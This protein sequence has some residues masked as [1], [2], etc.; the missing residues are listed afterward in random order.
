MASNYDIR[1]VCLLQGSS[2]AMSIFLNNK[3]YEPFWYKI[4]R[5]V[6][7]EINTVVKVVDKSQ[8]YEFEEHVPLPTMS[9]A[10]RLLRYGHGLMINDVKKNDSG[11]YMFGLHMRETYKNSDLPGVMLVV[12]GNT[13]ACLLCLQV[14]F[15]KL[16]TV[17]IKMTSFIQL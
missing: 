2:A 9:F 3:E 1:R 11:E 12:T 7:E 15:V 13:L 4:T 10:T 14:Y 8:I 6:E 16:H 17:Y 5:T